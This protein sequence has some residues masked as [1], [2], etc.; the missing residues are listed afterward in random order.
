VDVYGSA[1]VD[2]HLPIIESEQL[3]L[4]GP[5]KNL[6]ASIDPNKYDAFIFTSKWEGLPNILIEIGCL[7]I[8]VIAPDVGGVSELINSTTGYLVRGSRNVL[9]YID[10]IKSI[11]QNPAEAYARA[12]KL[13]E[14]IETR[15]SWDSFVESVKEIK[16]YV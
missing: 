13:Q 2:D 4:R 3:H 15:H 1:V 5:F 14:I 6:A 10:A 11:K 16:D 9:G 7:G 12:Q 8:P